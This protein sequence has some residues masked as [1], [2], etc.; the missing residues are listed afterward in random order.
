MGIPQ[1]NL[2]RS[3][4]GCDCWGLVRLVYR[5]ELA[6]DLPSYRGAYVSPDEREEIAALVDSVEQVGPWRQADHPAP[7]NLLV[8]RRGQLRSHLGLRITSRLMLHMDGTD[9]A[10]I[11]D[12]RAG[13][14]IRRLAGEYRY[15][16]GEVVR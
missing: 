10:R 2:G 11:A 5:R 13:R 14:W 16:P 6:I 15:S 4:L 8:F 3:E 12:L 9:Q 1:A 7:F